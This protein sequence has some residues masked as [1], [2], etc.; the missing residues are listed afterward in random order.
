VRLI[1]DT[2]RKLQLA[3]KYKCHEVVVDNLVSAKDRLKLIEY[4]SKLTG[5]TKE[6]YYAQA[7]LQNSANKWKN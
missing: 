3:G 1:D 7:A 6:A 5:H 2:E 4:S